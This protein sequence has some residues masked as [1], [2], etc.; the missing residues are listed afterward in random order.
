MGTDVDGVLDDSGAVIRTLTL[1]DLEK[2]NIKGSEHVDVTGGMKEK[3][4]LLVQL[5]TRY[6]IRAVLFNATK[7][8]NVVKFLRGDDDLVGTVITG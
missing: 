2:Q 6:K 4:E 7:D 5:A 8:S 1:H 3:V